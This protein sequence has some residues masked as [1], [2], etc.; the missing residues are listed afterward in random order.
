MADTIPTLMLAPTGM[1]V[2]RIESIP[3]NLVGHNHDRYGAPTYPTY[4]SMC[5]MGCD[6]NL[7]YPRT[8]EGRH[9]ALLI[10]PLGEDA[11]NA[12]VAAHVWAENLPS[13]PR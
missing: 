5:P 12:S 8:A 11:Y 1:T 2:G 13:A 4:R 9:E 6:L 7:M 10:D 3:G